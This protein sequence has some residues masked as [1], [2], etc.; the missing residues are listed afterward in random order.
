LSFREPLDQPDAQFDLFLNNGRELEHFHEGNLTHR[1]AGI[2]LE[3]PERYLEISPE[4]AR[5]RKIESGRWV[6]LTSR[7]GSLCVKV[8]VT[9]R[10]RGKQIFLPLTSQDGP[11]NI[12]TGTHSDTPT[13]TPAYKETA[14]KMEVLPEHGD[15]PL[16]KVNFRNTGKRTP[17]MGVEIERKWKRADYHFPGAAQL[18]QISEGHK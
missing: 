7:Y 11:V 9:D 5:E 18:V 16:M 6:R 14:V 4:L 2:H 17:Q 15:N 10:V 12:L 1:V 8:L 3:N 13:N